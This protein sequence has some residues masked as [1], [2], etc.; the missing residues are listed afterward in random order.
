MS[1]LPI[2]QMVAL[3]FWT[4]FSLAPESLSFS[5][6]HTGSSAREHVIQEFDLVLE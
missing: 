6:Y 2:W 3:S 1:K 5:P 4:A